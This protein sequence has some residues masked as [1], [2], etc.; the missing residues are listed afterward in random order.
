MTNTITAIPRPIFFLGQVA[1]TAN[2]M[3]MLDPA[4]IQQGL[5]RHASADWGELGPEDRHSNSSALRHGGRLFSA[6]GRKRERFW[7]ITEADRS[8]TTV[9]LP[10]DY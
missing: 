9:L 7:I 8:V 1:I 6:Y 10:L 4:E 3:A 2:A 5:S